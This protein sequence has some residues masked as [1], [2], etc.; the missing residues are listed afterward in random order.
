MRQNNCH[1]RVLVKGRPI[2]EYSKDGRVYVEGR[3]ET[4]FDIEIINSNPFPVAAVLSIDG[5]SVLDGLLASENSPAY[6]VGANSNSVIKGWKL[7]DLAAAAF[8]FTGKKRGSYVEQTIDAGANKGVI[9][10]LFFKE[11]CKP[12]D[13]FAHGYVGTGGMMRGGGALSSRTSKSSRIDSP[14]FSS[15]QSGEIEIIGS[16]AVEPVAQTLGTAFGDKTDFKTTSTTFERGDIVTKI[17]IYY[18]NS[19]GL[20]RRGIELKKPSRNNYVVD[21]NP[22]PAS[23]PSCKPPEGWRG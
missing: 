6:V 14:S 10:A 11:K 19:E 12:R 1:I 22:F 20:R 8:K 9:G 4:E 3:D 2:D 23:T 13:H 5:L 7:D 21:P 15:A 17:V 18:D 16:S